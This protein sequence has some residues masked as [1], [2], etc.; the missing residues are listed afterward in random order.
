MA[1][2]LGLSVG[3]LTNNLLGDIDATITL[4]A[5][6]ILDGNNAGLSIPGTGGLA[7]VVDLSPLVSSPG[8]LGLADQL[9]VTVDESHLVQD[10][11]PPDG[12]GEPYQGLL[13]GTTIELNINNG[14]IPPIQLP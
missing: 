1:L 3:A 2:T 12:A 8:G 6:V 9:L 11:I 10:D 7:Q 5:Q 4:E 13:D 14:P